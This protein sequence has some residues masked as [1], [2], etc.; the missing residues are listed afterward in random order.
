MTRRHHIH[1]FEETAIMKHLSLTV[2][3]ASL[4]L[5]APA[6]AQTTTAPAPAPAAR[7]KTAKMAAAPKASATIHVT[8]GIVKSIDATTLVITKTAAKGPE[9]T[10][11]LDSSTQRQG[12]IAAGASVDVRYRTEGKSRMATAIAVHEAKQPAAARPKT[13]K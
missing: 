4:L 1:P 2:A 13:S 11:T 6:L 7:H 10:F 5:A 12:T 3:L 9:T 8:R